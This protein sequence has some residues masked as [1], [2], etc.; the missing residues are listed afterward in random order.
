MDYLIQQKTYFTLPWLR[1]IRFSKIQK[2]PKAITKRRKVKTNLWIN[3]NHKINPWLNLQQFMKLEFFLERQK[4]RTPTPKTSPES[5][6]VCSETWT[7]N[8]KN[9]GRCLYQ[10]TKRPSAFMKLDTYIFLYTAY[11]QTCVFLLKNV[12]Y[13][14]TRKLGLG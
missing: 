11:S 13:S 3:K 2:A 9:G 7:L 6:Y 8:I 1:P 4:Y 5:T 12:T 10:L 14:E